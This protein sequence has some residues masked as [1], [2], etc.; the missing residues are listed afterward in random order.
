MHTTYPIALLASHMGTGLATQGGDSYSGAIALSASQS[1][2]HMHRASLDFQ[3]LSLECIL[4]H[5]LSL[6]MGGQRSCNNICRAWKSR[7]V[8]KPITA[9]NR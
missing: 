6:F 2:G 8:L 9:E 4:L 3:A 5:E 1:Y 7:P